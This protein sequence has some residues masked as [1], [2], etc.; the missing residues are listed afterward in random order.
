M[1]I[2]DTETEFRDSVRLLDQRIEFKLVLVI[3]LDTVFRYL[4]RD[5]VVEGV[6]NQLYRFVVSCIIILLLSLVA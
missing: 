3:H 2:R 4:F 5:F 1:Q 6:V